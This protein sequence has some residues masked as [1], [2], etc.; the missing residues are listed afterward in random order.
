MAEIGYRDGPYQGLL[1]QEEGRCATDPALLAQ[2]HIGL[3]GL[4]VSVGVHT[5]IKGGLV[6][7]EFGRVAL[8]DIVGLVVAPLRCLGK[9]Q[10]V[11]C[12]KILR[13][14]VACTAGRIG[15][16]ETLGVEAEREVV[17]DN[18]RFAVGNGLLL[19]DAKSIGVKAGAEG[20]LKVGKLF[21][22]DRGVDVA[23]VVMAAIE[24]PHG[25]LAIAGGR[26]FGDH[27]LGVGRVCAPLIGCLWCGGNLFGKATVR[28]GCGDLKFCFGGGGDGG[29][30][31]AG[32]GG[33]GHKG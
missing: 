18:H 15:G 13:T 17:K 24:P 11:H 25:K 2:S 28:V 21:D 19:D 3:D 9:E 20:A 16:G 1:I 22:D 7:L 31:A 26:A 33:R 14:L 12:P 32:D 23:H 4:E 30:G 29:G 5:V 8:E 10:V 27:Q 6:E